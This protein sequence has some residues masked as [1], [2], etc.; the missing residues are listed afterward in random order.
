MYEHLYVFFDFL[1]AFGFEVICNLLRDDGDDLKLTRQAMLSPLLETVTIFHE[2][3]ISGKV[4]SYIV[5]TSKEISKEEYLNK[6]R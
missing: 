2:T 3:H 4:I 1:T 6:M 5:L